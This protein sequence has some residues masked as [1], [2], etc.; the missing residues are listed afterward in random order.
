MPE[1]G[2]EAWQIFGITEFSYSLDFHSHAS[3]KKKERKKD[4][5]LIFLCVMC[6]YLN[7]HLDS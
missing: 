2:K 5:L 7:E 4:Y 6:V 3:L 1:A